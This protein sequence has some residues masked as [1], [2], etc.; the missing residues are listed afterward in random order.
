MSDKQRKATRKPV[1]DEQMRA[2]LADMNNVRVVKKVLAR[3]AGSLS[4]DDLHRCG[5]HALWK[6]LAYHDDSYRQKFTTT[7]HRFTRWEC[8]R[9]IRR[10][11]N[12]RKHFVPLEAA[13][14]PA[15]R[16]PAPALDLDV[17]HVRECMDRL[18]AADRRLLDAYYVEQWT[19]DEISIRFGMS[20]EGV[21]QRLDSILVHLRD[22]CEAEGLLDREQGEGLAFSS[23]CNRD[24]MARSVYSV[25]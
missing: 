19:L 2:A 18:P 20:K 14:E 10:Q 13:E 15:V 8:S 9:E 11:R 7:L 24:R 3:F 6:A 25:A 23:L 12:A 5:L 17:V 22:L 4:E 16:S 21:R 1:S